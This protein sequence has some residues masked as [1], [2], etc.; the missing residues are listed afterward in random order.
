MV[1]AEVL[2][3][4]TQSILDR[5]FTYIYTGNK[6]LEPGYRVLIPFNKKNIVGYTVSVSKSNLSKEELIKE[7]GYEIGEIIDVLDTKP[8]LNKD[9]LHLVD[10]LSEY[11]LCGKMAILQ[12]M[13]PPSLNVRKGTLTAPKIAYTQYLEV[14][15][16]SNIEG[17]TPRQTEIYNY[18]KDNNKVLKTSVTPSMAKALID[19]HKVHIIKEEKRRLKVTDDAVYPKLELTEDQK[20]VVDEFNNSSDNVFLLEGVTGSGKT[21]V[22]LTICDEY[23]KQGKSI[24]MLVPEIALTKSMSEFFLNRFHSDVAILHSSLTPAER[25]DEYRRIES[26]EAKIVVGA[27][28]AIFAPLANIGLIIL[29]EEHTESYKQDTYPYYHA[30]EVALIRA[31]EHHAKVIL[32]SATPSLESRA[33]A[34]NGVYHLLTLPKRI[35]GEPLPTVTIIRLNN[36]HNFSNESKLFTSTLIEKI[37]ERLAKH[38]QIIL[39]VNRRGYSSITCRECGESIICPT[40]KVP[41]IYHRSDE[42][43]KCHHCNYVREVPD[44]CPNCGSTHLM[45]LGYGT[46]KIEDEVHKLFPNAITLRLD[47]DVGKERTA[48][49]QVI[50]EFSN[51]NA[52]ILI[53][54]QMIAKGHD[55]KDVTLVGV[56]NADLG[57]SAPSYRNSERTFELLTQAIGRCG[58]GDKMGEA[59]IQTYN[60]SHYAITNAARQDYES[61]YKI[62]I[63]KRKGMHYPPFYYLCGVKISGKNEKA[64]IELSTNIKYSLSTLLGDKVILY[65]PIIPYISYNDGKYNRSVLIKYRDNKSVKEVLK[66]SKEALTVRGNIEISIDFDPYDF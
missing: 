20:R 42:T 8:I 28:S 48:M 5:S 56:I 55:F 13:L 36:H 46:E 64:V 2:V 32:G 21:E 44:S 3:E 59:I 27:R 49:R 17:L 23:L 10:T 54:T 52:D 29:D 24:L 47:S 9:L 57:L 35:N 39:L 51:H 12:C 30:R 33:K 40:C 66:E 6:T 45:K 41:L 11:Y 53:G 65:G 19:K 37:R 16:G 7:K 62:E 31:K 43:L 58:R 34:T 26:G 63:N 61:F 22:Y 60:P 25:Y 18:I 4:Y 15:K 38:E 50:D 1:I 14:V